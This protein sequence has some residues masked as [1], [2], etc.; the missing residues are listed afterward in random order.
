MII[1]YR[2]VVLI[3]VRRQSIKNEGISGGMGITMS[4]VQGADRGVENPL[5]GA[6]NDEFGGMDKEELIREMQRH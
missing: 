2:L 4:G 5:A 6:D 1:F 3:F